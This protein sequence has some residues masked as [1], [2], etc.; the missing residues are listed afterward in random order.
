MEELYSAAARVLKINT[1]DITD[2]IIRKKSLD[3]RK[4]PDIFSVYTVDVKVAADES[5]ILKHCR[6]K[7]LPAVLNNYQFPSA[8]T[9]KLQH[10]PVIAGSGPAGLSGHMNSPCMVMPPSPD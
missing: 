1:S 6:N 7:M 4:K 8:G 5:K 10:R 2:L 3:A 9:R